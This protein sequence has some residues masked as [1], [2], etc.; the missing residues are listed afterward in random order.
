MHDQGING[1]FILFCE[2][3][4]VVYIL[5]FFIDQ[6]FQMKKLGTKYWKTYWVLAEWA[7]IILAIGAGKWFLMVKLW[8]ENI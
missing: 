1:Q 6:F 3:V 2:V 4:F 8:K 5:Y 7:V